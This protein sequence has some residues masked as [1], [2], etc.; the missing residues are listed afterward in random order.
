MYIL[1]DDCLSNIINNLSLYDIF[2]LELTSKTY[3][4]KIDR[5]V[6]NKY[7][8]SFSIFKNKLFYYYNEIDI[9]NNLLDNNHNIF[10]NINLYYKSVN[11]N[12]INT[13]IMNI[14]NKYDYKKYIVQILKFYYNV[15]NIIIENINFTNIFFYK[16]TKSEVN[17]DLYYIFINI[18]DTFINF[19]KFLTLYNYIKYFIYNND[20]NYIKI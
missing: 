12:Y 9:L 5:Y 11:I 17:N 20:N 3:H 13:L 19:Y 18:K 4:K 7:N 10:N 14:K 1:Y 2:K 16:I 15:F 6:N 8:Q